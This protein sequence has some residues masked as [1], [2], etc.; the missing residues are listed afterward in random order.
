MQINVESTD[1]AGNFIGWLWVEN[2]NLSVALVQEGLAA[3]HSSAESSEFYRQLSLAEEAAKS[4]KLKV[5]M[6]YVFSIMK[7][8]HKIK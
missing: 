7:L 4:T 6:C 1:K 8:N 2:L 3:V 5:Q